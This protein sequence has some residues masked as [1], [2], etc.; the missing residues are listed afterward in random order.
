MELVILFKQKSTDTQNKKIKYDI[1]LVNC[2]RH[3]AQFTRLPNLQNKQCNYNP[4]ETFWFQT[5]QFMWCSE[6][7]RKI[8]LRPRFWIIIYPSGH[9]NYCLFALNIYNYM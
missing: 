3:Q 1:F 8:S 4:N 5:S 2:T 6:T 9:N 7:A